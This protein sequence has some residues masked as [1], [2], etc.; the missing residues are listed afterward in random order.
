MAIALR[1]TGS[2]N[3][4]GTQWSLAKSAISG[5]ANGDVVLIFLHKDQNATGIAASTGTD[6]WSE[7]RERNW[8]SGGRN[9]G[10]AIYAKRITDAAGEPTNWQFE[11]AASDDWSI[12][13]IAFSGV[14][15]ATIFDTS[16]EYVE[17]A[18]QDDFSPDAP[19]ITTVTA[20]AMVVTAWVSPCSGGSRAGATITE[21]SG[22]TKS[23]DGVLRQ[24]SLNQV[25]YK[26][27][28]AAGAK[29]Y[30]DWTGSGGGTDGTEE[31]IT[32]TVALKPASDTV[33]RMS[34]LL[35]IG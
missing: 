34:T 17:G 27:E 5:L 11:S 20:G 2:A 33:R 15:A 25:A 28:A 9:H 1:D 31:W 32:W 24:G 4:T 35:G 3:G 19:D 10:G 6:G 14:D 13:A 16:P 23:A 18:G 8:A 29:T 12:H 22:F 30:G 7:V 21:P 26:S